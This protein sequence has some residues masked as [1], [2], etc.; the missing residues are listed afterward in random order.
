MSL[1]LFFFPEFSWL[2]NFGWGANPIISNCGRNR[3][4][5]AILHPASLNIKNCIAM[6]APLL[7][8]TLPPSMNCWWVRI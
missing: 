7:F 3:F 1:T 6:C 2:E 8:L 5:I 4:I